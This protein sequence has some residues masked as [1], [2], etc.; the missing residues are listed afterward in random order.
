[1]VYCKINVPATATQMQFVFR[2]HPLPD[3]MAKFKIAAITE[4]NQIVDCTSGW[5]TMS[6]TAD[7]FYNI[8][9]AEFAGKAVTFVVMQDQIGSKSAGSYMKVSLMFRRCLF[10][11]GDAALERWIEDENYSILAQ[12]K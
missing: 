3:D 6:N 9:V 2:A 1:M 4:D 12:Q 8:D 7:M 10:N 11:V 5:V